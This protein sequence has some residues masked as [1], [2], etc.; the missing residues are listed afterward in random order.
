MTVVVGLALM[1]TVVLVIGVLGVLRAP[2]P[3]LPVDPDP[4]GPVPFRARADLVGLVAVGG[5]VGSVARYA[6]FGL[7][8]P[9][10]DGFPSATL[11]V[12]VAGSLALGFLVVVLTERDRPSDRLRALLGTGVCGGFTTMSTLSVDT[13]R[14]LRAGRPATAA[15]YVG[16]SLVLGLAAAYVGMVAGRRVPR[17]PAAR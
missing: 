13:D 12:N 5:A 11:G 6:V 17:H 1:A 9:T 14:L 3:D 2:V 4:V 10:A 8:P 16:A 15:A 7:L